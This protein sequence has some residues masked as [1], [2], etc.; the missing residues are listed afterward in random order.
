MIKVNN[1]SV[2]N[3]KEAVIKNNIIHFVALF[4]TLNGVSR[5]MTV[6]VRDSFVYVSHA[7]TFN[8]SI[9]SILY[10]LGSKQLFNNNI[11]LKSKSFLLDKIAHSNYDS[12]F[13]SENPI[14]KRTPLEKKA[15]NIFEKKNLFGTYK[16]EP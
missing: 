15:T 1:I 12:S 7:R 4:D 9:H 16:R 11:K 8:V 10:N 14:I 13:W 3:K 2:R 5:V 6:N